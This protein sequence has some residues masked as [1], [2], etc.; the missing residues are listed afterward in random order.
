MGSTAVLL[1]TVIKDIENRN[2]IIQNMNERPSPV[3][4]LVGEV[5][6]YAKIAG[7]I[8]SQG[9]HN[10]CF[11]LTSM[12]SPSSLSPPLSLKSINTPSD[13]DFLKNKLDFTE[14]VRVLKLT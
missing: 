5:F 2:R 10:E 13:E 8:P 9:M 6:Q 7:S 14:M 12:F 11:S 1:P 3:A 4:Q